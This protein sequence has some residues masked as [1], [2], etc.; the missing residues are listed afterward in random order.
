MHK[1]NHS[2]ELSSEPDVVADPEVVEKATLGSNGQ[3]SISQEELHLGVQN[4]SVTKK[5]EK[6]AKSVQQNMSDKIDP[7]LDFSTLLIAKPLPFKF[8]LKPRSEERAEKVRK[9]FNE[10]CE[11]GEY[12]NSREYW[13]EQQ[14]KGK[15]H[16]WGKV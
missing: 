13:G 12:E 11:K 15:E 5:V 1:A 4:S 3:A 14:G 6:I 2:D 8:T 10:G 9:M 7:T 16:G